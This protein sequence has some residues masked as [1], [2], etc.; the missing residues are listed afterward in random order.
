MNNIEQKNVIYSLNRKKQMPYRKSGHVVYNSG[1]A[2]YSTNNVNFSN[3]N[4]SFQ[5]LLDNDLYIENYLN[6]KS[7]SVGPKSRDNMDTD[8][9]G[10][11]YWGDAQ[12]D[13]IEILRKE[14]LGIADTVEVDL[15]GENVNFEV[16]YNGRRFVGSDEGLYYFDD[17]KSVSLSEFAAKGSFGYL[18]HKDR[19]F[20]GME[21][22]V[23]TIYSYMAVVDG[24]E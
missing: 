12:N 8:V 7:S 22:G 4:N 24:E 11:K 23:Y 5:Q 1:D 10:T 14:Q 2:H 19:L 3:L 16:E 21:D 18:E 17:L 20:L 15:K 13:D 9:N 6:G